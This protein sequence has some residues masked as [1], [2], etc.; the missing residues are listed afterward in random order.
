MMSHEAIRH[1]GGFVGAGL[2]ALATDATILSLLTDGLG[3]SPFLAR[4]VSISIAMVVSWQINRRITFD[5]K[6]PATFAEFGRFAAVSWTAQAV[7][8]T[9]FAIALLLMP[10]LWPVW[11]LIGASLL[12]MFVSYAGFRFGVFRKPTGNAS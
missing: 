10:G 3:Q 1:Y 11:A 4:L 5:M 12:A 9:V 2:A 7:N 6:T 8:Y